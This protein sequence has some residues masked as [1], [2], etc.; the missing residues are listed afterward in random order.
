MFLFWAH[1]FAS[2]YILKKAKKTQLGAE[3]SFSAG[4]MEVTLWLSTWWFYRICT[5]VIL[6]QVFQVFPVNLLIFCLFCA[7]LC[8]RVCVHLFACEILVAGVSPSKLVEAHG[9]F[10]MATCTVCLR[11]YPGEDLRPDIMSSKV[12][13]CPTCKGVIKPNIVFFGEQLPQNFFLYLTDFPLADLLIIMGTS[14]EVE[15][16]ASLAG[17]VRGSVPRLLINRDAVGPFVGGALR[18]N[19]VAELGDVVGGVLKLTDA[20]GWTKELEA[21]M[22][23]DRRTI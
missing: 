11:E 22:A 20:L 4:R 9:T 21:V 3:G 15:P 14:L 23:A 19:D 6:P 10:S 1:S 5:A 13:K 18:Q 7:H 17:V 16:F 8:V 2:I 12:P